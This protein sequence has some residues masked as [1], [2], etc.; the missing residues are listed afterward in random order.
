MEQIDETWGRRRFAEEYMM[1][2]QASGLGY[3]KLTPLKVPA[4][5]VE[6]KGVALPPTRSLRTCAVSFEEQVWKF[7]KRGAPEMLQLLHRHF[8]STHGILRG[9]TAEGEDD[10]RHSLHLN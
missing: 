10:G 9:V 7:C 2:W 8:V 3:L 6:S 4:R 5:L 1:V